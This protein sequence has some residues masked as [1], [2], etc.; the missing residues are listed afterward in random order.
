M[1]NTPI[2]LADLDDTLF[3]TLRKLGPKAPPASQLRVGAYDREMKPRSFMTA[4][5]AMLVDWMLEHAE[6]IPVTARGTEEISRVAIS[7]RSWAITTHGAVILTP[8]G[9]PD[10]EWRTIMLERLQDYH[11]RLLQLQEAAT[12]LFRENGIDGWARLNFEYG[13]P[14][15][16]VMKHRNSHQ[17]HELYSVGEKLE[18]LVG[19]DGFYIHKNSNNIAWL[20]NCVEKG[21]AVEFLLA[22]LTAKHAV[23]PVIG[24]GD[25]L[26]DYRFLKHCS[27]WGMPQE[28][29]FAEKIESNLDL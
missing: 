12:S 16:L 19:T 23:R 10:E 27:W 20:P 17:L 6:L 28:S 3:Q 1:P 22:K 14:I 24:L 13:K 25:S 7:F 11:H 8:N 4:Q 21:L 18:L 2:V 29:Q 15:Y 5:Q 9:C 26:S